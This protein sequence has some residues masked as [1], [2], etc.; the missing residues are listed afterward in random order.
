MKIKW[1]YPQVDKGFYYEPN[2]ESNNYT[3]SVPIEGVAEDGKIVKGLYRK[4]VK[5]LESALD[6]L[7][8][9]SKYIEIEKVF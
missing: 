4:D 8:I 2:P 3:I 7:P 1:N 9:L 5:N 6:N